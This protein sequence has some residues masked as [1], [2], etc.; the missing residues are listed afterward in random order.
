MDTKGRI[1][2]EKGF[3]Q[4]RETT[5]VSAHITGMAERQK[6]LLFSLGISKSADRAELPTMVA[7]Q[8]LN[9]QFFA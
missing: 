7:N 5:R 4:P 2:G 6:S 3:A 8:F 1:G 9:K